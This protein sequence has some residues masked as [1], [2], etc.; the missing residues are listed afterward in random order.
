MNAG[1][2]TTSQFTEW[3]TDS[4]P[5]TRDSSSRDKAVGG[6]AQASKQ[7]AVPTP[8]AG[9]V[10]P[11]L[12]PADLL[13]PPRTHSLLRMFSLDKRSLTS[14]EVRTAAVSYLCCFS[15]EKHSLE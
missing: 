15:R 2:K 5:V 13:A 6:G 3:L 7:V 11:A 12:S 4:L 10:S 8:S 14:P 1:H 9:H